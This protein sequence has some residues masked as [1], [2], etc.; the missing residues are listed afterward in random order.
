MLPLSNQVDVDN[1]VSGEF[2]A[3]IGMDCRVNPFTNTQ[4]GSF[5]MVY[6]R[7]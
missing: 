4:Y 1:E 5:K 2:E 3:Q 6:K 7:Y